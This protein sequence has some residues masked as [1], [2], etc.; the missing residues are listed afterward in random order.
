[1][2]P[3]LEE[4]AALLSHPA[5]PPTCVVPC[6]RYFIPLIGSR[7]PDEDDDDVDR[8]LFASADFLRRWLP[9][10]WRAQTQFGFEVPDWL[11][12]LEG[13]LDKAMPLLAVQ[14]SRP[15]RGVKGGPTPN[16]SRELCA[17]VCLD[18]WRRLHNGAS[19]GY[20][21]SLWQA[22][23]QYWQA[24]GWPETSTQ[25]RLKNWEPF[26]VRVRELPGDEIEIIDKFFH[27]VTAPK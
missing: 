20:S 26:L 8:K 1:M 25:G 14:A 19:K 22:C 9:I 21:Y 5:T 11:D 12:E 16:S 3:I 27:P 18:I 10:Y 13:A 4:I 15:R 6:L 24:C 7:L 17:A 23:E 2:T